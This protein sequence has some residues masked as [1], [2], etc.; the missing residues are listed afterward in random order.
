MSIGINRW[1]CAGFL[2]TRIDIYT[3]RNI[4]CIAS[5]TFAKRAP[6]PVK[7]FRRHCYILF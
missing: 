7:T 6:K 4:N 2:H 3:N 5:F 1:H